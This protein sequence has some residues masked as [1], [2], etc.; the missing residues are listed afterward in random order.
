MPFSNSPSK[1]FGELFLASAPDD[2]QN[3]PSEIVVEAK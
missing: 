1:F 3:L 2:H